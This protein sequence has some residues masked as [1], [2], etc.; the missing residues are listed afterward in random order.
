MQQI[1]EQYGLPDSDPFV[2]KMKGKMLFL[3]VCAAIM[4]GMLN[5]KWVQNAYARNVAQIVFD[6]CGGSERQMVIALIK[7]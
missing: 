7:G 6:G 5:M 2:R 3:F 4:N 1:F